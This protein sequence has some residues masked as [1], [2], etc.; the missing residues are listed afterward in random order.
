MVINL[1]YGNDRGERDEVVNAR[2]V[3][4]TPSPPPLL[5]TIAA[6]ADSPTPAVDDI[7]DEDEGEVY[8][9]YDLPQW[10]ISIGLLIIF[11]ARSLFV[12]RLIT[13]TSPQQLTTNK[14]PQHPNNITNYKEIYIPFNPQ[15]KLPYP[16]KI[17]LDV[18]NFWY[19]I[20]MGCLVGSFLL[21][22][23]VCLIT[24][25]LIYNC[26]MYLGSWL[27]WCGCCVVG[28]IW[29]IICRVWSAPLM[30]D[31]PQIELGSSRLDWHSALLLGLFVLG[32][33]YYVVSPVVNAREWEDNIPDWPNKWGYKSMRH[34]RCKTR[35]RRRENQNVELCC[36]NSL[37]TSWLLPSPNFRNPLPFIRYWLP[38]LSVV[39]FSQ[40]NVV[41]LLGRVVSVVA[42]AVMVYLSAQITLLWSV[43]CVNWLVAWSQ[44][45]NIYLRGVVNG[46]FVYLE[47]G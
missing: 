20:W 39:L 32:L 27:V 25:Q 19:I 2:P 43:G 14:T 31:Q 46:R 41:N 15:F 22:T 6:T 12:T 36:R 24:V 33:T 28:F 44:Q 30:H 34:Y 13:T 16:R 4:P 47:L 35:K 7:E 21:D 8:A 29:G 3:S 42:V 1:P 38:F 23:S 10:L 37:L 17:I 26:L 18:L 5:E 9:P 11:S 45:Y 40:L